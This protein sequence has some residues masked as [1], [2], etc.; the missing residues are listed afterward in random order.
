MLAR[1]PAVAL[2]NVAGLSQARSTAFNVAR[3]APVRPQLFSPR[4]TRSFFN[5]VSVLPP[6]PP[7]P[8][9]SRYVFFSFVVGVSGIEF[10][11]AQSFTNSRATLASATLLT[12]GSVAWYANLYGTLPFIGE[13]HANSP[14]EEGLHPTQY[15]WSHSGLFDTFDH[16]R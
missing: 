14:A 15:P 13:V 8:P 4:L 5:S 9:R 12:V 7:P 16:A 2:K 10:G 1:L 11:G 6:L 3:A